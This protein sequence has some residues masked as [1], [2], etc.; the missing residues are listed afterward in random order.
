RQELAGYKSDRR[1]KCSD[2]LKEQFPMAREALEAFGI[3]WKSKAGYEA[4]DLIATYARVASPKSDVRI[5]SHDKDL[6]QLVDD[7]IHVINSRT[8]GTRIMDPKHVRDRWG[9]DPEQMGDLLALSGDSSDSIPGVPGIGYRKAAALLQRYRDLS[10][11]LRSARE[12]IIQVPGIGPKLQQNLRDFAQQA[13]KMREIVELQRVPGMDED[14]WETDFALAKRNVKWLDHAT[15][16]CNRQGMSWLPGRA[17]AAG[18]AASLAR[19]L[20]AWS[21]G[22]PQDEPVP[23]VAGSCR[24]R[25]SSGILG[26]PSPNLLRAP[27]CFKNG[28]ACAVFCDSLGGPDATFFLR[29][30]ASCSYPL[31]PTDVY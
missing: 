25:C 17:A 27:S 5:V 1:G 28:S 10:G 2:E 8:D 4:D 16:W 13:E 14:Q 26:F 7:R 24:R 12:G 21:R 11:V 15:N 18:P 20:A 22:A 23:S 9:V 3:P 30:P 19:S 6:L 29:P 31:L